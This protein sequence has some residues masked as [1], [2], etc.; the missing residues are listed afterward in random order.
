MK[1]LKIFIYLFITLLVIFVPIYGTARILLPNWLKNY[2]SSSL[3]PGAELQIGEME[4]TP[5]MGVSYKNLIFKN[6]KDNIQLNL[7]DLILEP[8]LSISKP[9]NFYINSGIIKT[10]KAEFSFKNL[11]GD[12]LISSYKENNISVL[13]NI[14]EIKEVDKA[15]FNNI[16]YFANYETQTPNCCEINHSLSNIWV[17]PQEGWSEQS[18]V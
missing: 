14:K 10:K 4:S 2:V 6:K 11:S 13:G 9:A 3:P 17:F 18:S 15:I 12:I 5:N 16:V 1:I 7:Q 8:N